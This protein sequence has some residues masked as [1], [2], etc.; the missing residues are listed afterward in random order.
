MKR[1]LTWIVWMMQGDCINSDLCRSSSMHQ[2]KK[3]SA[4]QSLVLLTE[5]GLLTCLF[6]FLT[7]LPNKPKIVCPFWSP[8]DCVCFIGRLTWF[9]QRHLYY[10]LWELLVPCSHVPHVSTRAMIKNRMM[11]M[12]SDHVFFFTTLA[13]QWSCSSG[14]VQHVPCHVQ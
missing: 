6:Y 7:V 11:M 14:N 5:L 12:G 13:L 9:N 4:A 8:G 1:S 3:E 2:G 10:I